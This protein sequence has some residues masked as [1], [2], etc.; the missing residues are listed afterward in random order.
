M[1]MD[2]F[3]D[4]LRSEVMTEMAENFFS[5]RVQLEQRIDHFH[6]M[7]TKLRPVGMAALKRWRTLFRLLLGGEKARAHLASFGGDPDALLSF[8]IQGGELEPVK[9]PLALTSRGR[10]EKTVLRCHEALREAAMRYNEGGYVVDSFD[11]RKKRHTP[12]FADV[13][14]ECFAVNA[15]ICAVNDDQSPYCVLNFAKS[16]DPGRALQ[17]SAA[18]A[19]IDGDVTRINKELAFLPVIFEDLGLPEI[20]TPPPVDEVREKT[21]RLCRE[22][23]DEDPD[24]AAKI[25]EKIRR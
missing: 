11:P 25:M 6:M 17:E 18:G 4:D 3:A 9:A 12:G 5:R 7:A 23:F 22:L 20:P 16:L 13:E 2:K 1:S 10:Y 19:V 24:A 14:K 21:R 15:E 8:S